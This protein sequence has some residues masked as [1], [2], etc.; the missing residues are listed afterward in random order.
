MALLL[1]ERRGT[2]LLFCQE[3]EGTLIVMH[4]M[5][6]ISYA[7]TSIPTGRSVTQRVISAVA[8]AVRLRLLLLFI[9]PL[10][11]DAPL[12]LVKNDKLINF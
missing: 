9:S 2:K 1:A 11:I 10:M 8:V 3:V 12:V 5:A 4:S 6:W 7:S